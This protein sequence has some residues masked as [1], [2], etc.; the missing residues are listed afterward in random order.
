MV[1]RR[2]RRHRRLHRR[3]DDTAVV[4]GQEGR[5]QRV[6][7]A[8]RHHCAQRLEEVETPRLLPCPLAVARLDEGGRCR[9]DTRRDD[10][11]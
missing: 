7:H 6:L 3:P 4:L 10:E 8:L 5:H 2:H 11:G 9:A 1:R